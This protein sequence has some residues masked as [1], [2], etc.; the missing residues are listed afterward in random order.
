MRALKRCGHAVPEEPFTG[1]MT[2][3]M[4]CHE[5]YK[6]AAGNWLYPEDVAKEGGKAFQVKTREP[7]TVG[8]SEKMSKSKKN[9]VDP[10]AII[11]DY[12]ADTARL[13]MLS[14][15]P[16]ERDL[17]W[18]DAGVDGAW[19]YLNRLWRLVTKVRDAQHGSSDHP[20]IRPSSLRKLTHKTI[21][22]VTEDI[23]RF[24]FNKAV[25]RIRE[26]SNALEEQ[27]G[28]ADILP[29]VETLILL[30]NPLT[31]HFAAECWE[32]LGHADSLVHHPWPAY[33]P[34]LVEDETVTLAVQ[35]N[36]KLRGTLSLARDVDNKQ[37][38]AL[39][40]SL[41]AVAESIK[42]KTVRKIIVVPGRIVN[43]VAA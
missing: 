29:A 10:R 21:K 7:V 6:D 12:G 9:T 2:Q 25:A 36:G 27:A 24:H 22:G 26:F 8:R 13:F 38:E 31:P 39:A 23:A 42:G 32:L 35:V 15:S 18:T 1:L 37:A 11:R 40:L 20:I 30:L 33:D 28:S 5:T 19:R 17:E 16:P 41:P 4:V 43:V 3:G 14:D 34:A